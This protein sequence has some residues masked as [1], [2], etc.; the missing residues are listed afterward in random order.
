MGKKRIAKRAPTR[1]LTD[2]EKKRI[3]KARQEAEEDKDYIRGQARRWKQAN[4]AGQ[5]AL[6]E[7]FRLL[8]EE[9]QRQSLSLADLEERTGMSR[10]SLSRLENDLESN[11]AITTL[12]R[13]AEALGKTLVV[14]LVDDNVMAKS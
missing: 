4:L 3:A 10:P 14:S 6:R 1:E 12:S 11:P 9:R 13:Y 5:A 8:K 2:A 7:T